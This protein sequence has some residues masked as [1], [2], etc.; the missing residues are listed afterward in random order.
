MEEEKVRPICK[1]FELINS[2]RDVFGYIQFSKGNMAKLQ[3]YNAPNRHIQ[4]DMEQSIIDQLEAN[5][6]KLTHKGWFVYHDDKPFHAPN[7]IEKISTVYDIP[8]QYYIFLEECDFEEATIIKLVYSNLRI[9]FNIMIDTILGKDYYNM[10]CDT[11]IC[12]QFTC[13]DIIYAYTS[14]KKTIKTLI[15]I[16]AFLCV[17]LAVVTT[18][19]LLK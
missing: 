18:F 19:L 4:I 1:K 14:Q 12:D 11:Y 3:L 17:M 16:V 5:G 2:E 7:E 15:G 10:G 6:I 13:D 8:H 9:G